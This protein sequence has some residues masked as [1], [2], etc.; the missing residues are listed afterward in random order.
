M[1]RFIDMLDFR[2][3]D[4]KEYQYAGVEWC[5]NNELRENPLCE[6]RGGFFADEMGLGKTIVMIGTMIVNPLPK[7]LIVL[8]PILIQQ[9]EDQ[10]SNSQQ[11]PCLLYHGP[12]KK[13]ITI[14]NINSAQIVICSYAGITMTKEQLK[15]DYEYS[16]LHQVKWDRIIFDESHHMRNS[17]TLLHQSALLLKSNIRWLVSGTPVQNSK[18]DLY[19]LCSL[20]G[21]PSSF[22]IKK[23]N[24]KQLAIN[25]ILKRTKKQVG[26]NIQDLHIEDHSVI[27]Q[28]QSEKIFSQ[29]I[30]R[31]LDFARVYSNGDKTLKSEGEVGNVERA[32]Q[33]LY[34][35]KTST[36]AMMIKAKQSCIMPKLTVK[37]FNQRKIDTTSFQEAFISSSKIDKIVNI[38][39]ERKDNGAGKILFCSYKNEID[40]FYNILSQLGLKI[41]IIDGRV[42]KIQR[43]IILSQPYDVLI[44]QIQTG[45]EGLNLQQFYSEIYFVSPSWNPAVEDQA[46]AR[47][48]RIGQKK[49]VYVFRFIMEGFD[50]DNYSVSIES[51][52]NE[53][54]ECKR[55]VASKLIN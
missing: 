45:C 27:W 22:Y 54:Q 55:E 18:N 13:N 15:G 53:T 7:T 38:I 14:D 33:T 39:S 52:T 19:N 34:S 10:L 16:L 2:G 41:A 4:H 40:E 24:L 51:Y 49:P 29:Q 30:H 20:L 11:G 35:G 1:D 23:D 5:V 50:N 48:H 42:T 8:P 28:R 12:N 44:L 32:F 26:I 43:N 6:V 9:W 31:D 17:S 21:L 37:S 3:M 46:I 25:F 47:C 36:L